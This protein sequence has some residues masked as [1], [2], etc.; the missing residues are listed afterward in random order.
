MTT[1]YANWL[2]SHPKYGEQTAVL[3]DTSIVSGL[4]RIPILEANVTNRLES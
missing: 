4:T 1:G 2:S 3:A